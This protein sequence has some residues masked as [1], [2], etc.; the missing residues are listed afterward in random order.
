M[1]ALLAF[2]LLGAV[3]TNTPR[4]RLELT[5]PAAITLDT[6]HGA[7]AIRGT[8]TAGAVVSDF[9]T[10]A[11]DARADTDGDPA[12][13]RLGVGVPIGDAV[14]PLYPVGDAGIIFRDQA[15]GVDASAFSGTLTWND[16]REVLSIDATATT[17]DATRVVGTLTV[18]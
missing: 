6:D 8:E 18:E 15:L 7:W 11:S 13:I 10:I 3:C 4:L 1:R 16:T 17:A 14:Q 12:P 9:Y 2:A 5:Q